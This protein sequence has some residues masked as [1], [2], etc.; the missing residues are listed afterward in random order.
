MIS[1]SF[2]ESR[3]SSSPKVRK[4]GSFVSASTSCPASFALLTTPWIISGSSKG[5]RNSD[6]RISA[7]ASVN[8]AGSFSGWKLNRCAWLVMDFRLP[9]ALTN[10]VVT[11]VLAVLIMGSVSTPFFLSSFRTISPA[12]SLPSAHRIPVF[13]PSFAAAMASF[14]ASPPAFRLPDSAT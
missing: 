2:R 9:S 14:T 5:A 4:F 3:M 10:M 13:S 7:L 8:S 1:I 12:G 6:P 11:G